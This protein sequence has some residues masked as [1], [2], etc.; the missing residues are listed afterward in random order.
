MKNLTSLI[1]KNKKD[2]FRNKVLGPP[3]VYKL[4][5][6]FFEN[7]LELELKLKEKF[8]IKILQ[9]LSKLYSTAIEYYESINSPKYIKYQQNL[10]LLFSDPDI[11]RH[12]MGG[13]KIEKEEK[14][15]EFN[16][17]LEDESKLITNKDIKKI[18]DNN[19]DNIDFNKNIEKELD[20]Q[21]DNF[22]KRKELKKKKYL[23]STSDITDTIDTMVNKIKINDDDLNKSMDI[24]LN[25]NN[26][27]NENN[28]NNNILGN[29]DNDLNNSQI[30]I[31]LPDFKKNTINYTNKTKFLE[32]IKNNMDVYFNEYFDYFTNKITNNIIK[33]YDNYYN[34]LNKNLIENSTNYITQEKEMEFLLAG[35]DND[36][37]YNDQINSIIKSLKE[38]CI[39]DKE[40]ILKENNDK[41]KKINDK[42]LNELSNNNGINLI[43]EKFKLDLTNIL[44]NVIFK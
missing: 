1:K 6:N 4:P 23:L 29:L 5:K 42:Y 8:D 40:K 41:L 11:K 33:D 15:E 18:I 12:M 37:G 3:M 32:N 38:D 25:N 7:V 10:N 44:S 19:K 14:L 34:K 21:K 2:S 30:S 36:D 22:K 13:K 39:K 9:E 28:N 43:Q 27:N 16:K 17:K 31:D 24:N 26:K 20:N 35:G